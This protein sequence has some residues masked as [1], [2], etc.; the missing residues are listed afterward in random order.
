MQAQTA[1][2]MKKLEEQTAKAAQQTPG[3][4]GT[5]EKKSKWWLW[6]IIVIAIIVLGVG[7]YYWLF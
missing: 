3:K 5:L 7:I 2:D 6:L 4:T 1:Q